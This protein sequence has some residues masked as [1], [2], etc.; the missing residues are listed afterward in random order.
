M[1][2]LEA[3]GSQTVIKDN[4]SIFSKAEIKKKEILT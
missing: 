3:T 1:V 4:I 2:I